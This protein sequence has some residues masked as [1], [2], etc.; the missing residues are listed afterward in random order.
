LPPA[1]TTTTTNPPP[2]SAPVAPIP[3]MPPVTQP[4]TGGSTSG[5]SSPP[6]AT[7]ASPTCGGVPS[8]GTPTTAV[9]AAGA[10]VTTGVVVAGDGSGHGDPPSQ[11]AQGPS[12]GSGTAGSGATPTPAP[13]RGAPTHSARTQAPPAPDGGGSGV[14]LLASF[15]ARNAASRRGHRAGSQRRAVPWAGN[16]SSGA[17][18]PRRPGPAKAAA[19]NPPA[20]RVAGASATGAPAPSSA[21]ERILRE[22]SAPSSLKRPRAH[23]VQ[24][25]NVGSSPAAAAPPQPGLSP[26][27]HGGRPTRGA[28]L[29]VPGGTGAPSSPM[30]RVGF[31]RVAASWLAGVTGEAIHLQFP[32]THRLERPG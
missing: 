12:I 31:A 20:P 2:A 15:P 7:S 24:R 10:T 23:G 28:G 1:G 25:S 8:C 22:S 16:A 3:T 32:V 6:A 29:A 27:G 19:G 17:R 9:P 5:A 18:S 21:R 26:V 11:P 4:C 13:A 14:R 30:V